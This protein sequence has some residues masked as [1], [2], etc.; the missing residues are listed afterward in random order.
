[1]IKLP[2]GIRN[3]KLLHID[4]VE[5]GLAC[6][7]VCSCCGTQL[8]AKKG[9]KNAHHFAHYKSVECQYAV[10][11]AV[12]LAAK[13]ILSKEKSFL[14][15]EYLIDIEYVLNED[16]ISFENI[17][18]NKGNK[19]L[20]VLK[21]TH[22]NITNVKLEKRINDFVP[23]IIIEFEEG[24]LYE[25]N[26][27]IIEIAV[28]HFIDKEKREKIRNTGISTIEIDLNDFK[29]SFNI[30]TLK[31][32]LLNQVNNKKWIFSKSVF[33]KYDG[34]KKLIT[35][36]NSKENDKFIEHHRKIE[37]KYQR[38]KEER[39]KQ[40]IEKEQKKIEELNS[41]KADR[42][43]M[44]FVRNS[45]GQVFK[46]PKKPE[47]FK[48]LKTRSFYQHDIVRKIIDSGDW[49][50]TIYGRPPNG[51]YIFFNQKEEIVYKP[52]VDR[53]NQTENGIPNKKWSNFHR[54]LSCIF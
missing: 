45:S 11:T 40:K 20:S 43:L 25:E 31:D 28:T 12:H 14:I 2:Y 49:N 50:G 51:S 7:C 4:E 19:F 27:L 17:Y 26:Q 15:P 32:I 54:P 24:Q 30:D 29:K 22:L 10:E 13:E 18:I 34:I 21:E 3:N 6:N 36:N 39:E 1:M 42:S 5:N 8:S 23:D 33:E 41:Y 38:D 37:E 47:I 35:E 46:C 44:I 53:V 9:D 52:N 16:G 48:D